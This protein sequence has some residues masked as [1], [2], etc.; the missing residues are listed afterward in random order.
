MKRKMLTTTLLLLAFLFSGCAC[1]HE[2]SEADCLN[3]QVCTKCQETGTEALGH[4][5]VEAT[6]TTAETCSRCGET[7]AEALGHDWAVATCTT[8]ETC[9]RCGEIQGEPLDHSFGDWTL[10]DT[11]MSHT[12]SVCAL[13]ETAEIDRSIYLESLLAGLWEVDALDYGGVT[14][15]ASQLKVPEWLRFGAERSV[16]GVMNTEPFDGTWEFEGFEEFPEEGSALYRFTIHDTKQSRSIPL[17]FAKGSTVN[18]I[19]AYY[20]DDVIVWMDRNDDLAAKITGTWESHA[21]Y[22]G[23]NLTLHADRTVTGTLGEPINGTWQLAGIYESQWVGRYLVLFITVQQN[24]EAVILQASITPNED[25][26]PEA[27]FIPALITVRTADAQ[28]RLYR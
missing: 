9:T 6:C 21:P 12:C 27:D 25:D 10:G 11:V 15:L 20:A 13:E 4:S 17:A 7:R 3:P 14:Y 5:W 16:T 8:P 19:V 2:W 28:Y 26:D 22:E 23:S 1:Q 24:S 18:M